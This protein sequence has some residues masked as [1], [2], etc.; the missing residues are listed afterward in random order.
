MSCG[1]I[2]DVPTF[3]FL[4]S[5]CSVCPF[6][7]VVHGILDFIMNWCGLVEKPVMI[8]NVDETGFTLNNKLMKVLS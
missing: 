3:R 7:I 2:S 8:H 6:R 4:M 5:L 1:F